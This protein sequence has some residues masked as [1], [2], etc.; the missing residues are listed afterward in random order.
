MYGL[1]FKYKDFGKKYTIKID[2]FL[3][4][5]ERW[6]KADH[7]KFGESR[8]GKVMLL[9]CRCKENNWTGNGRT[10]DEYECGSC[11]TFIKVKEQKMMKEEVNRNL[12]NNKNSAS[13]KFLK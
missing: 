11:G 6:R 4:D 13:Q 3:Y 7:D 10:M 8:K 9:K 12:P 5:N 2:S 1:F